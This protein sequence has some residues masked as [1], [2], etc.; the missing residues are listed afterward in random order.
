MQLFLLLISSLLFYSR[1]KYLPAVFRPW[2]APVHETGFLSSLAGGLLSLLAAVFYG[3]EYGWATGLLV[4]AFAW[5]CLLSLT[6]VSLPLIA[7]FM[8]PKN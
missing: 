1:S 3:L 2:A 5:M 4:W 8:N 6:V 7:Y